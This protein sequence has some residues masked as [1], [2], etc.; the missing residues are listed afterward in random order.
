MNKIISFFGIERGDFVYYLAVTLMKNNYS[1]A[2][3]DNSRNKDIFNAVSNFYDTDLVIKQDI[4]YYKNTFIPQSETSN[5]DFVLVWQGL[6]YNHD[7]MKRS[8]LVYVLPDYTPGCIHDFNDRVEDKSLI[9]GVIL[10]DYVDCRKVTDESIFDMLGLSKDDKFIGNI[11]FDKEDYEDYISFAY[12]GRQ[13]FSNIT[14]N[15]IHV[16]E[17]MITQIADVDEK[18]A[19]DYVKRGKN[20]K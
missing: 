13:R 6:N 9:D 8:D 11:E 16:L 5:F 17:Y 10:R 12:E 7:I 18:T 1:V 19:Q 14:A 2:V 20:V 4:A 15:F 3:L